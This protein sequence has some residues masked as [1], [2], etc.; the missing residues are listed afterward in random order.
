[1]RP[2]RTYNNLWTYLVG[3]PF[4]IVLAFPFYWMIW[5]S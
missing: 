3:G 1:M 5:T 4:A 2:R